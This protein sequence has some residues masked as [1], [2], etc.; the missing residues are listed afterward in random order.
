[1]KKDDLIPLETVAQKILVIRGLK[2]MLDR[3]LAALYGVET[4]NLNKAVTRNLARFPDD[5]MFRLTKEE[6]SNLRFHFGT[7]RWG[8]TRKPPRVFTEQ[9]VAM[10]SS[11][12]RS[13]RAIRV[14]IAIMRTFVKLREMLSTHTKLAKSL[15]RLEKRSMEH[16]KKI[17]EIYLTIVK[18]MEGPA[19]KKT[20]RIG[21]KPT[22]KRKKKK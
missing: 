9:G 15:E 20:Q 18:L 13:K 14:N 5:F 16:D 7:S 12:L 1:M 8:G 3:D 10:L 19:P 17:Q 2:V 22:K 6:F 11:V 21:F 4:K